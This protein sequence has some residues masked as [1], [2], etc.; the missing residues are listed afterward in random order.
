M[1]DFLKDSIIID[2]TLHDDC[3]RHLGC[4]PDYPAGIQ[5]REATLRIFEFYFARHQNKARVLWPHIRQ[6][7]IRKFNIYNRTIQKRTRFYAS[8]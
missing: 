4:T 6:F 7:R 8:S 2:F 1:I 5:L 3:Q